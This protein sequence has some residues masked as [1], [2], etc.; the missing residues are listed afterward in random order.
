[1]IMSLESYLIEKSSTVSFSDIAGLKEAKVA[2]KLNVIAPLK[3][4][5]YF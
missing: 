1:M 3:M 5:N 2:L 4:K